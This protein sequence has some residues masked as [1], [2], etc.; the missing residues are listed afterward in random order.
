MTAPNVGGAVVR[1][2]LPAD[3][4]VRVDIDRCTDDAYAAC[5]DV[6]YGDGSFE[7]ARELLRR[8]PGCLV[9]LVREACTGQ[10]VAVM[11]T[12]LAGKVDPADGGPVGDDEF[13][14][15]ASALH[16]WLVATRDTARPDTD[17]AAAS[18]RTYRLSAM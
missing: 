1:R 12:G 9:V 13:A 5:A 2:T 6:L 17:V 14:A 4:G 11:R 8:Y 3:N 15:L 16:A 18:G 10:C 7:R